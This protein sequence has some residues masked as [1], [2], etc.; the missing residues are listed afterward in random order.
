MPKHNWSISLLVGVGLWGLA[1]PLRSQALLPYTP[2]LNSERLEQ[3]GLELAE[4]AIQ[5]VRFQQYGAALSRAKLATQL[6]PNRYQA[7]FILGTLYLQQNEVESG[8]VALNKSLTLAPEEAGILFTLGNAYFQKGDYQ[9]AIAQLEAGLKLKPNTA[10]ALF[11]LGNSHLKL[12]QFPEAIASYEK[13]VA[14]EKN[15]WP[16]LNNIGL[17]QYERGNAS[18]A[19]QSW[20][21]A[22]A[23]DKEQP[24]P[25]L[26]LAVVHF[27][28]GEKEQG[29]KMGEA[30]LNLDSRYADLKFLEENLWGPRLLQDTKAF[31]ATPQMQSVIVHLESQP[32]ESESGGE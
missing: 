22:I 2:Q 1:L 13:A 26:A 7:W 17:V 21:K 29:F 20:E 32:P 23:I 5:L 4:D 10:A 11:D 12:G 30:A 31:L 15:F 18:N 6:A 27:T 14:L 24:E 19:I 28:R 16:A 25:Q 3:Q 8:I 9:A